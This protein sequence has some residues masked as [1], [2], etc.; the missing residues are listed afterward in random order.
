MPR[1]SRACVRGGVASVLS[2]LVLLVSACAPDAADPVSLEVQFAKG[3]NPGK[4]GGG[5]SGGSLQLVSLKVEILD[6]GRTRGMTDDPVV[7]AGIVAATPDSDTFLCHLGTTSEACSGDEQKTFFGC[8]DSDQPCTKI[9]FTFSGGSN[10]DNIG[11]VVSHSVQGCKDSEVVGGCVFD[12]QLANAWRAAGWSQRYQPTLLISEVTGTEALKDNGDT[13]TLTV[14]WQ[15]QRGA[16]SSSERVWSRYPDLAPASGKDYFVFRA[17]S[18]TRT[19][20]ACSWTNRCGRQYP[21]YHGVGGTQAFVVFDDPQFLQSTSQARGKKKPSQT[22]TTGIEFEIQAFRSDPAAFPQVDGSIDYNHPDVVDSNL[23]STATVM[24]VDTPGKQ[25]LAARSTG[26]NPDD[27]DK[28]D[29]YRSG[30]R[31][32]FPET[33]CYEFHLLAVFIHDIDF[34]EYVWYPAVDPIKTLIVKHVEGGKTTFSRGGTCDF[35]A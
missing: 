12:D 27:L 16:G 1:T 14:Y 35:G 3:G 24:L 2:A 26:I 28:L 22:S 17:R 6:D 20:A 8:P 31:F 5:G 15:G 4:P 32:T 23:K 21:K 25:M 10:E 18:G 30:F 9:L 34:L 7:N 13:R 19:F 33:G 29:I 11:A